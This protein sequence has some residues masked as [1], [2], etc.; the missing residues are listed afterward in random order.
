MLTFSWRLY[1]YSKVAS[2]PWIGNDKPN[3]NHV[4]SWPSSMPCPYFH[5]W[6]SRN[7]CHVWGLFSTEEQW[8]GSE[9]R[10]SVFLSHV[11]IL[12]HRSLYVTE[13]DD[14]Q[15]VLQN[16]TQYCNGWGTK[17]SPLFKVRHFSPEH[18]LAALTGQMTWPVFSLAS[19]PGA[20]TCTSDIKSTPGNNRNGTS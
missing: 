9:D 17:C 14:T 11:H 1:K 2:P 16:L 12:L 4:A 15:G 20:V 6:S 5:K 18:R 13:V 19:H 8:S 3:L 7:F 10:V